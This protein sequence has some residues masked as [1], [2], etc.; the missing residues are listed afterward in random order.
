MSIY[1]PL[2]LPSTMSRVGYVHALFGSAFIADEWLLL[3]IQLRVRQ[4]KDADV[5]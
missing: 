5:V 4:S 1:K 3:I 2:S